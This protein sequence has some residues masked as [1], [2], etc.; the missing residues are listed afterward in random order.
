M[1]TTVPLDVEENLEGLHAALSAVIPPKN[2]SNL[3]IGTWNLRAFGDLTSKWQSEPDDSPKRDWYAVA[4]IA[5][6]VARFDVVAVQEVRRK[7][8]GVTFPA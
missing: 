4:C 5:E 8:G 2:S 6:V 1:T 3:L 7:Y